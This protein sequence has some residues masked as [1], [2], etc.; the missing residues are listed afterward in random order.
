MP[1]LLYLYTPFVYLILPTVYHPFRNIAWRIFCSCK[2]NLD[3]AG[4]HRRSC[5]E[6]N[7][8]VGQVGV[9][10]VH[11]VHV[12]DGAAQDHEMVALLAVMLLTL[13]SLMTSQELPATRKS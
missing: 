10:L 12:H 6:A 8:V 5:R 9:H 1:T 11:H 2:L 13:R 3:A 4:L 7:A